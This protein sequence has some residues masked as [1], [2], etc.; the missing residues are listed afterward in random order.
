M[1]GQIV[2]LEIPADDT[3]TGRAFWGSL[4]GWQFQAFPGPSE[5]HMART[6]DQSGVAVTNMEPGKRGTRPYFDVDDINAGAARVSE[7]GGTAG[8][9]MPVP[10]M[11]WF[12]TCTDP[13]GNEFGLWQND[14]SAPAPTG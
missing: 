4:F 13:H 5:Y 3:E 1:P 11:G 10:G 12:S 2:H 7:L 8:E 9:P 14:T 6:G